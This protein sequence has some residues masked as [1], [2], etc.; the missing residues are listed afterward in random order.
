[1]KS[2]VLED[3]LRVVAGSYGDMKTPPPEVVAVLWSTWVFERL[4]DPS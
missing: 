4:M 3:M 1:L 2:T